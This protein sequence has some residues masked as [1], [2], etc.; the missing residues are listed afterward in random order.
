MSTVNVSEMSV[1]AWRKLAIAG[2]L[3][4]ISV[5]KLAMLYALVAAVAS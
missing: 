3:I 2:M 5:T 4:S 1:I